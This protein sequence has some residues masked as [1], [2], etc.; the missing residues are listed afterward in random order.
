MYSDLLGGLDSCSAVNVQF[1]V[2]V[3]VVVWFSDKSS[4]SVIML[5]SC[6]IVDVTVSVL[7]SLL[8][9]LASLSLASLLLISLLLASLL[10]L[11]S[12]FLSSLTSFDV[13]AA[14]L[15]TSLLVY[16]I[17]SDSFTIS[18]DSLQEVLYAVS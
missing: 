14:L 11:T 17:M 6:V 3:V 13:G 7:L 4:D 16:V 5:Q 12:L 10:L 15:H 8:L 9:L 2:I 18:V 1:S